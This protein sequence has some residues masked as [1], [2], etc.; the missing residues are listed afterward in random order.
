MDG[1]CNLTTLGL[2]LSSF[3]LRQTGDPAP[4]HMHLLLE[5]SCNARASVG[6][7]RGGEERGNL[8]GDWAKVNADV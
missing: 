4:R 8:A 6:L 2:V 3:F 1:R 7:E 5:C